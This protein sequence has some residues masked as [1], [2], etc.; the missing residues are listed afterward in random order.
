M[1]WSARL[2][3]N[4]K[5]TF[6]G[7]SSSLPLCQTSAAEFT[8]AEWRSL[9]SP[10]RTHYVSTFRW[11]ESRHFHVNNSPEAVEGTTRG[12]KR[13][14]DP[15]ARGGPSLPS[16]G[17]TRLF[18]VHR[19]FLAADSTF[20]CRASEKRLVVSTENTSL[21]RERVQKFTTAEPDD[22]RGGF[23]ESSRG[24]RVRIFARFK[25]ERGLKIS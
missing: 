19:K 16:A 20:R 22:R 4:I 3:N 6:L 2:K 11:R 12:R 1:F 18:I 21:P 15:C 14:T 25:R 9:I 17:R 23:V 7:I 24:T 10:S 8:I 5:F 13:R